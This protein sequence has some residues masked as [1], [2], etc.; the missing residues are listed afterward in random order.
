ML[1][2]SPNRPA[3][4]S[5]PRAAIFAAL[6]NATRLSIVTKLAAGRPCSISELTHGTK[7]TRQAVT[8]HLR[9]LENA[10]IVR[11]TRTGRE[12]R[13]AFDP[14]PLEQMRDYLSFVSEQWDHALGR[15]KSLV[16]K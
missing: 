8:K 4:P 3:T 14:A 5:Q 6:G 2:T 11:S 13:F 9:V 1:P 12:S 7:L 15:L 10:G 16:E